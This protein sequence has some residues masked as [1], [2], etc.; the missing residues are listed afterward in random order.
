M[1]FFVIFTLPKPI[2]MKTKILTVALFAIVLYSCGGSKSVPPPPPSPQPP[3]TVEA[4]QVDSASYLAEGK[5]LYENNCAKCHS[6]YNPKDFS[7]ESWK[8]ILLDMQKKAEISDGQREKIY[9]YLT[10]N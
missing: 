5:S 9:S 4:K 3:P 8:P 6:L 2:V 10:A 1:T 7:K